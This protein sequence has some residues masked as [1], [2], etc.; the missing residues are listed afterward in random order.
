[1][2][3]Q[4]GIRAVPLRWKS[5][6]QDT[7]AQETSQLQVIS[8]GKNLPDISISKSRPSSTQRP[9]RYSSGLLRPKIKQDLL[10]TQR[11]PKI[12]MGPLTPQNTPPDVDVPTRKTR[13]SLIHQNTGTGPLLQ[14]AYTTHSTKLSHRGQTPKRTETMNLQ[15]AIWRPQTQ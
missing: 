4:P 11:L 15:P 6:V 2:V 1:M 3:L 8:N 9:A 12:M 13:S 7:G 5:Q 14:E 10:L